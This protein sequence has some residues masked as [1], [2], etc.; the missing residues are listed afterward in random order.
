MILLPARSTL[1]DTHFPDT[2]LCRSSPAAGPKKRSRGALYSA[3]RSPECGLQNV[4]SRMWAPECG[5]Q[6]VGSRMWAQ[7]VD[8]L[9][10]AQGAAALQAAASAFSPGTAPDRSPPGRCERGR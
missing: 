8:C 3:Y 5:L 1:T 10:S 4:G 7:N 2:T 6:N 9:E